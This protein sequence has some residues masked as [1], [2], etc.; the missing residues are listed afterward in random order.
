MQN[1]GW[2]VE[3]VKIEK[4]KIQNG[5]IILQDIKKANV[6]GNKFINCEF[7]LDN[8]KVEFINNKVE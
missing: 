3:N 5:T 8:E 4:N 2:Y 7:E 6:I 1:L